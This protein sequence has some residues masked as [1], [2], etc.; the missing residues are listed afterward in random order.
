MADHP[1]VAITNATF[2]ETREAFTGLAQLVCNSDYEPWSPET[3]RAQCQAATG[4]MVFM[5]DRIDAAFFAACP[6]V[7]IVA[8][9]LKG[10][11]NIDVD[12]A[13]A[14]GVWVSI[15][16]DLLTIPTAELAVGLTLALARHIRQGDARV[17]SG[18]FRGWR[19]DLYGVG[20]A[21][22]TVGLIGYGAVGQAIAARLSGFQCRV[23]AYDA[24]NTAD[25]QSTVPAAF[26][27]VH[28]AR[29]AD[30]IAHADI[31]VLGLPLTASTQHLIN[32]ETIAQMR[33]GALLI[34][35]ARGSLVDEAA[36]ADALAAGHLGGYAGDVFACEDWARPD[37][38]E[39]IDA[40]LLAPDA[41]TVLTPHIGSA[42][43]DV[44][45]AIEA[46]AA[47]NILAVLAGDA[48]PDA[49]NQ[50]QANPR[51]QPRHSSAH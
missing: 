19:P 14:A 48:P 33:P 21:G 22:A 39:G 40:R 41:R 29:L 42:V 24:Q 46:H 16:P 26:A 34:N 13:T 50:P 35:P 2:P 44:R 49:I 45:R 3:L 1:I 43:V 47:R 6:E 18:T 12:A 4:V 28:R 20:L 10:Y 5:T 23:L 32:A 25:E 30:V 37:R 7:R 15:V 17:R 31:L 51:R 36:V 27:H 11:D 38:P 8:A 9:A